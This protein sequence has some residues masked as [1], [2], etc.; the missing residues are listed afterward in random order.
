MLNKKDIIAQN[1]R[2]LNDKDI[3]IIR[4]DDDEDFCLGGL[5]VEGGGIFRKGIAVGIQERMVPG[6]IIYD[7]ENF[8]GFSEKF[9]LNLLSQHTDYS[10]LSLPDNFFDRRDERNVLQPKL[11][12]NSDFEN[13]K[14]TERNVSKNL[15]IDIQIKDIQNFYITIPENYSNSTFQ[16][17]FDLN[18]IY[19]LNIVISSLS[20]V[21]INLSNKV[22]E[23]KIMNDNF[24]Y[25]NDFTNIIP[26][27]SS[28]KLNMEIIN[29]F[30]F[31]ISKK[32]FY[33]KRG[34]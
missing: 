11:K 9:G 27:K 1:L 13:A 20:L 3:N 16:L 33:Q 30:T 34:T 12:E 10:E 28:Y 4:N 17:T 25:E 14:N 21:F 6:L 15:A 26:A 18:Y 19:D 31:M 29:S 5:I 8:Y 2:V 24:Y 32:I 23:L 22:V 7:N